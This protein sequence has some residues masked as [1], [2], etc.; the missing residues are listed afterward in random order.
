MGEIDLVRLTKFIQRCRVQGWAGG[1]TAADVTRQF[2]PGHAEY[3][4]Y[5]GGLYYLDSFFGNDY[6]S[7]RELVWMQSPEGDKPLWGFAYQGR[8]MPGV[9]DELARGAYGMLKLMLLE[10][11][12]TEMFIPRGPLARNM[13]PSWRYYS[14]WRGKLAYC[15]GEERLMYRGKRVYQGS[16]IGSLNKI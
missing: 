1:H 12:Q 4:F 13:R 3:H 5:E 9:V 2:L 8:I 6:F 15:Q 10:G 16:Y 14:S 11:A 7:G